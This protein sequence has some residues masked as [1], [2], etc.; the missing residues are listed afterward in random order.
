MDGIKNECR[1]EKMLHHTP[2]AI[3]NMPMVH[4]VQPMVSARLKHGMMNCIGSS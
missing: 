1:Q 4:A 3:Q 2:A